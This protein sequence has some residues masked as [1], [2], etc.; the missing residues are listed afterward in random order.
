MV[1]KD[2]EYTPQPVALTTA[3]LIK[4]TFEHMAPI[5]CMSNSLTLEG[6]LHFNQIQIKRIIPTSHKLTGGGVACRH[7]K[8][9]FGIIRECL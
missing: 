2:S 9:D 1:K 6:T 7:G 4:G 8:C 5:T 3:L